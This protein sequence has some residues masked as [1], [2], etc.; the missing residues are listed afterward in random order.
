MHLRVVEGLRD[1]RVTMLTR[2]VHPFQPI[3][4]KVLAVRRIRVCIPYNQLGYLREHDMQV[5][6]KLHK[7]NSYIQ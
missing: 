1:G 4:R 6:L 7:Y 3:I 2:M 5:K